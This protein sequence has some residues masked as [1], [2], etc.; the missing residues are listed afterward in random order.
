MQKDKA[1][2]FSRLNVEY[3]TFRKAKTY[4]I[5][6]SVGTLAGAHGL[7]RFLEYLTDLWYSF[8]DLTFFIGQE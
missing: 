2:S 5:T 3:C 8:L 1:P 7:G 6:A 4:P